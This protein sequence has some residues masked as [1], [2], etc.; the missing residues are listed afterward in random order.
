[1]S[2]EV[3]MKRS[4]TVTLLALSCLLLARC[5]YAGSNLCGEYRDCFFSRI[6]LHGDSTF[7]YEWRL[8]GY[9]SWSTGTWT[10][11]K[12]TIF[13]SIRP[14]YDT[15]RIFPK[16][17]SAPADSLVIS[18]DTKTDVL[19]KEQ[20]ETYSTYTIV[21]NQFAAPAKLIFKKDRLYVIGPGGKPVN[22]KPQ[23]PLTLGKYPTWY[24]RRP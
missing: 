11:M 6:V 16:D 23:G 24:Q 8:D 10:C 20:F 18:F 4:I 15:L 13:F 17:A 7:L 1:M 12:D 2:I 19:T 9:R 14:V 21:Q 22:G 5:C 3:S